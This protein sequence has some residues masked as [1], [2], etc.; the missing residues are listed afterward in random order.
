MSVGS[1]CKA[2]SLADFV[3]YGYLHSKQRKEL[4][5]KKEIFEINFENAKFQFMPVLNLSISPNYSRSIS[6]VIQPDGTLKDCNVHNISAAPS[7]SLR[8]PL[9]YTGGLISVGSN[10]NIYKNMNKLNSYT[11]YSSSIFNL[12]YSQ[13]LSFFSS[14]KWSKRSLL[15]NKSISVREEIKEKLNLKEILSEEYL[16]LILSMRRIEILNR[17]NSQ[18]DTLISQLSVMHKIGNILILELDEILLTKRKIQLDVAKEKRIFATKIRNINDKYNILLSQ[19]TE[20]VLPGVPV[21]DLN[22]SDMKNRLV[23]LQRDY[24]EK[25]IVDYQKK[26]AELRN[27]RMVVPTLQASI[28]R[29]GAG[30]NIRDVWDKGQISYNISMAISFSLTD[31]K[32]KAKQLKIAKLTLEN[33]MIKSSLE[34]LN[35]GNRLEELLSVYAEKKDYLSYIETAK[36]VF[37]DNIKV[38]IYL[39]KEGIIPYG[40][41]IKQWDSINQLDL[42]LITTLESIFKVYYEISRLLLMDFYTGEKY[43]V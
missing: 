32:Q 41:F 23:I 40:E 31:I 39:L 43:E 4:A 21:F 2:M 24:N 5:I 29:S 16:S 14:Y 20:F 3:D 13:P 1:Y 27:E 34:D 28:G 38:K 26:I 25:N 42:D 6:S 10:L 19:E 30:N 33:Y 12:T 18:L 36:K 37:N 9:I 22:E 17:T 8:Y 7:I 15:A 35:E 11:N